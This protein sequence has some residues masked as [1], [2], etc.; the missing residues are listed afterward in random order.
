MEKKQ[1]KEA[2]YFCPFYLFQYYNYEHFCVSKIFTSLLVVVLLAILMPF[3]EAITLW[4]NAQSPIAFCAV[5]MS[6]H[7]LTFLFTILQCPPSSCSISRKDCRHAHLTSLNS[8]CA[9]CSE[10]PATSDCMFASSTTSFWARVLCK[11]VDY[12]NVNKMEK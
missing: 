8:S 5:Y 4:H 10:G 9:D 1:E 2:V 6:L 7:M 11:A 3:L 12:G